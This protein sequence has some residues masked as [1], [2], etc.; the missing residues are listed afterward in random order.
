MYKEEK[1]SFERAFN[2]VLVLFVTVSII[3]GALYHDK[4]P[5][6]SNNTSD[7]GVYFTF[8]TGFFTTLFSSVTLYFL[9]KTNQDIRDKDRYSQAKEYLE[10]LLNER[11][12]HFDT[13]R[14]ERGNEELIS[15]IVSNLDKGN[16]KNNRMLK[17]NKYIYSLFEIAVLNQE[18]NKYKYLAKLSRHDVYN[19]EE[20][21]EFINL[22][23]PKL[24]FIVQTTPSHDF[25]TEGDI[26]LEVL[27][28]FI[29]YLGTRNL[30]YA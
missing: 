20:E 22:L 27:L 16:V 24:N 14:G 30:A 19:N 17:L 4:F 10:L 2:F 13:L 6:I 28:D 1:M 3:S 29:K 21:L 7:W 25:G 8:Y 18:E 9:I 26:N 23:T 11:K 15:S 5:E 12:R